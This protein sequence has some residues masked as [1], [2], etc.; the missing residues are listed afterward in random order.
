M[1][2]P[3]LTRQ[4]LTSGH[5][6]PATL[7]IGPRQPLP[8]RVL[9][10]GEGNFLRSFAD[11][12]IDGMNAG[13]RF[14]GGI[15]VVQ[16][17][18]QG[19]AAKLNDQGGCYTVLSRGM[20]DGQAVTE[21]QLVTSVQRALNP[22][23]DF[24]GYRALAAQPELRF[25]VSNTTEAG[26]AYAPEA[27]VPTAPQSRFP[28]KV[29]AFLFD[30]FQAFQGD[31]G[32]GL[33][34]LPC[35]LINHNGRMLKQHVVHHAQDWQLGAAFLRWL[36]EANV[37]CDTLVDRIVP[38][39]PAAEAATICTELGYEDQLLS[40][41][42]HF[43]LWVIEGPAWLAE[44]LPLAKAGYNVVVTS[45]LQ[46]YRNRKVMVLN[47]AH[48]ASVLAAFQAGLDTVEQM[49][50][51][52]L[53]GDVVR[54]LVYDEV[55]PTLDMEAADKEGYAAAVIERF[56]NPFIRHELLSISLN[57]VSKWQVRVLPSLKA[58]QQRFGRLPD[59][60]AFSLAALLHFYRGEFRADGSFG[61]RRAGQAYPIRD[62]APILAIVAACRNLAPAAYA[63]RILGESSFWGEDLRQ[64]PGLAERVARDLAA[65]ETA[66][67]RAALAALAACGAGGRQALRVHPDDTVAVALVALA[68]GT[69]V[70]IDSLA[71]TLAEAIP[72]GHKFAVTT[73][74]AGAP[75]IKYASPI[76]RASQAIA[77]GQWVHEHNLATAL[78]GAQDYAYTPVAAP[79]TGRRAT[80]AS[81]QFSGY[82]RPDGQAGIRNEIWII[83]TV[84]C[85][86]GIAEQIRKLAGEPPPGVDGVVV[87]AHP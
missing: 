86:N 62:D 57:S 4:L 17:I 84:G 25:V 51:D 70:T 54:Q 72:A 32:K 56:R 30:R 31:P 18:S 5:D 16:P 22:Y 69:T 75:V 79:M 39:Y 20:V 36:D 85:V 43:H 10:F 9:Q 2:M 58:F 42:E 74:P 12:M 8:E 6:F 87:L 47:G 53:T 80:G 44:E 63:D 76:G 82:L 49:M 45:D 46:P 61:G 15:V 14:G 7:A 28:A 26:I 19:L 67:M 11:W 52:P 29:C 81:G 71:V 34:F 35:E 83:P 77:P 27:Y 66:G 60:L 78:A 48:T 24:T 21:R 59:R 55:L 37:F 64:I 33:V 68:A 41:G 23:A 50:S 3:R 73:I 38:G 13:G 1:T 40:V 65:I